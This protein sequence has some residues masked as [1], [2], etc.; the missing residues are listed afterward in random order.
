M[1]GAHNHT[2]SIVVTTGG[3]SALRVRPMATINEHA[4]VLVEE[5]R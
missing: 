4:S 1:I 3:G 5:V 2:I